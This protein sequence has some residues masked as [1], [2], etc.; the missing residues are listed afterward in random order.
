MISKQQYDFLK[1]FHNKDA[2]QLNKVSL[3]SEDLF[4]TALDYR[5]LI[6]VDRRETQST[7]FYLSA[8][9][10]ENGNAAIEE[11][12]RTIETQNLEKDNHRLNKE[13]IKKAKTANLISVFALISSFIAIVSS[14]I[15]ALIKS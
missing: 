15:L 4:I 7:Y 5:F 8:A 9:I 6:G 1:Q 13:A 12:E 3:F 10:T 2:V 14:I 11:Y